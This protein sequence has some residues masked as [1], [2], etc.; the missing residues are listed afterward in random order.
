MKRFGKIN[1][2]IRATPLMIGLTLLIPQLLLALF[3]SHTLYLI[4]DAIEEHALLIYSHYLVIPLILTAFSAGLLLWSKHR[5]GDLPRWSLGAIFSLET[6]ALTAFMMSYDNLIP[7]GVDE[8]IVPDGP[9]TMLQLA[10]TMPGLFYSFICLANIRLFERTWVNLSTSFGTLVTVP[11]TLYIICSASPLWRLPAV[12]VVTLFVT[13]TLIAAFTFLQLLLWLSG[14]L[15]F[16]VVAVLLFALLLPCGGL[17]LNRTIPFPSNLQHWGFYA[18]TLANAAIL[19]CACHPKAKQHILCG[20]AVAFSYPFTCYFFLLFL[21]FLPFSLLAMIAVGAGFLILTPTILFILHTRLLVDLFKVHREQYGI[22]RIL[23]G[24][25]VAFLLVPAGYVGRAF[26]HHHVFFKTLDRVYAAPLDTP[27]PMPSPRVAGYS[28]RRLHALKS[29]EYVPILSE[30]YNRIVFG[31]MVLPDRKIEQLDQ[32]LLG[33]EFGEV[34]FFNDFAF[35]SFFTGESTR[36]SGRNV[37]SVSHDVALTGLE[38]SSTASNG[39][40]EATVL[41]T[42]KSHD[43]WQAEYTADITLPDGVFVSGYE[44]K[45]GDEMVPARLSDRRA[46]LWV[47]HMIRDQARRDPGL[48]FYTG[49]HTLH[50]SV[51]PFAREEERQCALKLL[52]PEN[53]RPEIRIGDRVVSLPGGAPATVLVTTPAGNRA[54]GIPSEKALQLPGVQRKLEEVSLSGTDATVGYCPEWD[55]KKHLT[56]YWD[57]GDEQLDH[58]LWFV[59]ATEQPIVK[60]DAAAYWMPL[61]P[62]SGWSSDRPNLRKVLP[63]KCGGQV[64]VIPADGGGIVFFDSAGPVERYDGTRLIPFEAEV[65]IGPYTRYARAVEVWQAWWQSQLHPERE[66][67]LRRGLLQAAREINILIPSTAFLAVESSP[68]KKALEEAEAK[69]LGSHKSLAFDEFDDSEEKVGTPEPELLI[70]IVLFL[71]ILFGMQKHRERQK[72]V[73]IS[74]GK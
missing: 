74:S 51:F 36:T 27:E 45:I 24:F 68:Q 17:A 49:P 4:R 37:K 73:S 32:L 44:L 19:L 20:L 65:R 2:A 54:V 28:L 21:P 11:A 35:Y 60:M 31:G 16:H 64:R 5:T 43:D 6:A 46:A 59:T 12:L 38:C 40:T 57:S 33:G 13:A 63:L 62:D 34:S 14:R 61:I 8:W 55:V 30:T 67:E 48:I 1:P 3:R 18:L 26:Y 58:V 56:T 7:A 70:L 52:Y 39:V 47:Y 22:R 10:A 72:N 42:L 53:A 41:L 66:D 23:I 15:R 25:I 9:F 50:L 69:S 71:P 29:G